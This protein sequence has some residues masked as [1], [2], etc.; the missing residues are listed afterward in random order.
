MSSNILVTG[1]AGYIGSH[2]CKALSLSGL[3]PIVFDN[4]ST[5]HRDFVK[6]GPVFEGDLLEK[7]DINQVFSEYQIDS[8]MHIAGKASVLESMTNPLKYYMENIIGITNLLETFQL[9]G[10]QNFIFSSSCATYGEPTTPYIIESTPQNPI[11]PYGFSKLAG[12]KLIKYLAENSNFNYAILRYFNVAGADSHLEIGESH[13]QETHL[14]PLIIEAATSGRKFYI[15]GNDYDTPDGTPVRDYIH[16]TDLA[17]AHVIAL[18]SILSQKQN[19]VVNLG[20]GLALSIMDVIHEARKKYP[21]L[22]I[23]FAQRRA[24]DPSRLVSSSEVEKRRFNW[25]PKHSN[26]ETIFTSAS[27]WFHLNEN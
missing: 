13:E 7:T 8:V 17:D 5:G 26:L 22:E 10:G 18:T 19:L 4:F 16:V 23:E 20:S 9:K 27:E 1:G 14:I 15:Y 6:W 2:V 3:T 11:N 25:T 21:N 12:E 24:G